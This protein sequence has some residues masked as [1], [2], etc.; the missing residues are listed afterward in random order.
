VPARPGEP[1]A[2]AFDDQRELLRTLAPDAL[3]IFTPHLAHYRPAMDALQAGCH[4]FVERPLSASVQEAVDVAGLAQG[5][6]RK[7]AVGNQYRLRPSLVEARR[8][9]A[10]QSI[11]ALRLV[12]AVLSR[13]WLAA[14]PGKLAAE[15]GG[16]N[17]AGG[18]LCDGGDHLIDALLWTTGQSAVEAAALQTRFDS[19]LFS[20][21]SRG[22]DLVTAAVVRLSDQTP[23]TLA[24]CGLSPG[25]LFELTYHGD[26]GRLRATDQTLEEQRGGDPPRPV[27][28]PEAGGD[29]ADSIDGNFVSAVRND[30]PLCCPVE[31]TLETVRLLEAVTRS[32]AT[33]QV[34]RL[35]R[36]GLPVSGLDPHGRAPGDPPRP[37]PMPFTGQALPDHPA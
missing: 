30:S 28:L 12:T 8:R 32:A 35:P 16:R 10:G 21:S 23:A 6:G 22:A 19:T 18:F 11:G 17:D 20:G 2:E 15:D 33:G 4:V 13:E 25:P 14:N 26:R 24:V 9:L 1:A 5:R 29:P 37:T 3:A 27:A 31:E 7:V 36:P 34:V